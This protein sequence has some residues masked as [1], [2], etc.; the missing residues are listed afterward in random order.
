M[1]KKRFTEDQMIGGLRG[2]GL[3]RRPGPNCR[4]LRCRTI[5]DDGT[6]ESLALKVDIHRHGCA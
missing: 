6:R 4:R 3:R 5:V 2:R 1:N